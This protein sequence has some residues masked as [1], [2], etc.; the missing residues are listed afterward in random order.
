MNLENMIRVI[1][2]RV[3]SA[4]MS[5]A[6]DRNLLDVMKTDLEKNKTVDPIFRTYQFSNSA[7]IFGHN[8]NLN[9]RYNSKLAN[10]IE[11]TK[12]DT[13]GGHMYF[14]PQDIHFSFIS[15]LEF[16][17]TDDVLIQYK[18]VN[19]IVTKAL[20]EC[21]YD[22]GLGR[23]S[24]RVGGKIIAGS[25][26][27]HED[28]VCLHHGFILFRDYD[29]KIFDLLMARDYEVEKW[30]ELVTN[31]S[32]H[33]SL[34]Y[35]EIP[36]KIISFI[37]NHYKQPLTREEFDAA[38]SICSEKYQNSKFVNLGDREEGICLVAE[39]TKDKDKN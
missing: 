19:E 10:G 36:E 8:Q 39:Y 12:R 6:I 14:T 34:N 16:Y 28:S 9:G 21:G 5:L 15:P 31:L 26:R 24:I 33:N 20:I 32:D 11:I 22:A 7:I 25:A 29:K 35:V 23:T 30:K 1:P 27:K 18:K 3:D 17:G 4:S 37:G 2:H 13:G 38:V